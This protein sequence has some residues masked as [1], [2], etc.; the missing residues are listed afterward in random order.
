MLIKDAGVSP[1]DYQ[2]PYLTAG[3]SADSPAN[4][5]RGV[6]PQPPEGGG[7][8]TSLCTTPDP[9]DD[10]P[11]DVDGVAKVVVPEAFDR[12]YLTAGHALPSPADAG[13]SNPVTA[14]TGSGHATYEHAAG[15]AVGER[16]G[17]R[18]A[19]LA[20]RGR[21]WP[22]QETGTRRNLAAPGA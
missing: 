21:G 19:G 10:G 9:D 13:D 18:L 8:S 20:W 16:L 11:G 2:R 3:H 14:V 1:Q 7:R 17:G 12:G 4:G 6:V 22:A 5:R 15:S